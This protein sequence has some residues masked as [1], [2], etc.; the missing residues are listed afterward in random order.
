L[1]IL[2]S[3]STCVKYRRIEL[4]NIRWRFQITRKYP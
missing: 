3:C 4:E 2:C 1:Y